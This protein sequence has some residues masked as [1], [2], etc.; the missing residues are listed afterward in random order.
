MSFSNLN[1]FG[2]LFL[3]YFYFFLF[4]RQKRKS[5][6]IPT[7][8]SPRCKKKKEPF[9]GAVS[10]FKKSS[11]RKTSMEEPP[12]PEARG[13]LALFFRPLPVSPPLL[14]TDLNENEEKMFK[15]ILW[16]P[17]LRK[18]RLLFSDEG[19][20]RINGL[21]HFSKVFDFSK[22][23]IWPFSCCLPVRGFILSVRWGGKG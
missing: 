2:Q 10:S 11:K 6:F 8:T 1:C 12:W 15:K 17:G 23:F 4:F 14:C 21:I 18:P 7:G 13:Q 9:T 3:L 19:K 5:I 16:K 22:G 20:N